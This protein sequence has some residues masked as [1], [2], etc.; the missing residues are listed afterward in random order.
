MDISDG[1]SFGAV[2]YIPKAK[3]VAVAY[4]EDILSIIKT[5]VMAEE[6]DEELHHPAKSV[7]KIMNFSLFHYDHEKVSEQRCPPDRTY[8]IQSPN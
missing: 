3:Q 1:L 5:S 7:V 8:Y 4:A 6:F 2:V